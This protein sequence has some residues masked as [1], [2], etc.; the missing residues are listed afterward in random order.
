MLS[1]PK[2]KTN[3]IKNK[4]VDSLKFNEK[5]CTVTYRPEVFENEE[6]ARTREMPGK[7]ELNQRTLKLLE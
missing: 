7:D 2:A 3:H 4:E 5:P 6:I 1:E